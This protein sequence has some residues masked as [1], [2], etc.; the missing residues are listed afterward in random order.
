MKALETFN[1]YYLIYDEVKPTVSIED[2]KDKI[3]IKGNATKRYVSI[4]LEDDTHAK[5]FSK[6]NVNQLVTKESYNAVNNF[7]LINNESQKKLFNNEIKVVSQ[8]KN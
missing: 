4:I 3:I 1:E 5:I 6:Y 2:N 7:E 8:G